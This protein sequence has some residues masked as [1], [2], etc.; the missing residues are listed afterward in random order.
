MNRTFRTVASAFLSLWAVT[1]V[2]AFHEGCGGSAGGGDA[3]G[4]EAG[5][6]DGATDGT[7]HDAADARS[8]H[9]AA[10][11]QDGKAD[12]SAPETAPT[13]A[14]PDIALEG[15]GPVLIDLSVSLVSEAGPMTMTLVPPFSPGKFDYY[16]RC[17]L[18]DNALTVSMTAAPGAESSLSAPTKS[19]Q[20]PS[21]TVT[22]DVKENQAI[23]AEATEGGAK[24]EYWVRCLPNDFPDIEID[25]HPEAGTPT[26]G[27]YL[28]GNFAAG[29]PSGGYAMVLNADGV[30][31][32]YYL[33]PTG[34]VS[35]VDEMIKG[36]ISYLQVGPGPIEVIQIDPLVTSP[37]TP[38]NRVPID[39]HELRILK[40]GHYLIISSPLQVHYDLTGLPEGGACPQAKDASVVA[41]DIV[42]YDPDSGAEVWTWRATDHFDPAAVSIYPIPGEGRYDGGAPEPGCDTFHCNAIDEDPANGNLLVSGREM[43]SV[44]YIDKT[45][46]K[47]LWKMGGSK[48]S[49]DKATY[50]PVSSP[51]VG[52]HDARLQ[53][54]WSTC[55]GG[56][57]SL[58]DDETFTSGKAR[59]ALYD[60][61]LGLVDGGC[62][63]GEAGVAGATLA[64][65]YAG[66]SASSAEGSHRVQSDGTHVIGWGIHGNLV[67]TE[68]DDAGND[69]LDCLSQ[70]L[71]SFPMES[72]RAIKVPVT[73]LD[74]GSM[75]KTAGGP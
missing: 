75:R 21:Q 47:V 33:N 57:I 48:A 59:G 72:Y 8:D 13:D 42:E 3:G 12:R 64:W 14:V 49:L 5:H 1:A 37:S 9:D 62:D 24:T 45:T 41:C 53:P 29:G 69:L 63:G 55:S 10:R 4:T 15:G 2:V 50:I 54:G 20:K 61:K 74:L 26:P 70:G 31:V 44:F 71:E 60:V 17:A 68:V 66:T 35:N 22:L 19:A 25:A 34:G 73:A 51:F 67:F 52:Q 36:S 27:Y 18:A 40:N 30:P 6:K 56:Q 7:V 43:D 65:E 38:S 23:V 46:K 11:P 39:F 28:I 16:V 32:W 58:F